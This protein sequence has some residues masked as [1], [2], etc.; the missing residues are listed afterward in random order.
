MEGLDYGEHGMQ[1][2]PDFQQS[3]VGSGLATGGYGGSGKSVVG[4]TSYA[5]ALKAETA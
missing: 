5:T 1:A 4:T 3:A 2:Y